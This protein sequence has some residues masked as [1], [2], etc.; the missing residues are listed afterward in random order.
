MI[1]ESLV[2]QPLC[3]VRV[4]DVGQGCIVR[5]PKDARYIALSNI[6]VT[7][8]ADH[9]PTLCSKIDRLSLPGSLKK[10]NL[11]LMIMNAITVCKELECRYLWVDRFCIIQ[12]EVD[13]NS[14]QLKQMASLYHHAIF[15]I[16]AATGYSATYGLSGVN[17]ARDKQEYIKLQGG[18][19]IVESVPNLNTA[20]SSSK[21]NER[22][23]TYQEHVSSLDLLLFTKYGIYVE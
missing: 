6:W 23:W 4:V 22:G 2:Y 15:I 3:D 8:S 9:F 10:T 7:D 21:W 16:V 11:P 20:L 13:A 18:L 5:L 17:R 1:Q 19:E 12:D 14:T